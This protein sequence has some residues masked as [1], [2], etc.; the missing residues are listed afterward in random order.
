MRHLAT[1]QRVE[2]LSPIQ[3]ADTLLKLKLENKA[4]P[5]VVRKDDGYKA[6]DLVVYCEPD[7]VLPEGYPEFE[8]LRKSSYVPR[9]QGFRIRTIQLRGQTSQGIV[10][11]ITILH[12]FGLNE[13]TSKNINEDVTERMHVRLYELPVKMSLDAKGAFPGFMPKTD[14]ERIENIPSIVTKHQDKVFYVTEKVDGTSATYYLRDGTFGICSRTQELIV[15]AQNE[16]NRVANAF[17]IEQAL[18]ALGKNLAIQGEIIGCHPSGKGI[19]GNKYK[20]PA[21]KYEYFVFS[22][23]DI[24]SF[25]YLNYAE[26]VA[27]TG[28]LGLKTVPILDD[29]FKLPGTT[30]EI[31]QMSHGRSKIADINREGIVVRSVIEDQDLDL[32]LSRLS[33]K[34]VDPAFLI[35]YKE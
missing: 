27:V 14:E 6:G 13:I 30:D 33:F 11:P 35:E 22:I 3:N 25:K 19:A 21:G 10:F 20:L 23:F 24:D 9:V 1:I 7:S 32:H 17:N 2:T 12:Q 15:G 29:H 26:L 4:W 16:Y 31:M 8:F 34:S 28:L 5:I 18:R